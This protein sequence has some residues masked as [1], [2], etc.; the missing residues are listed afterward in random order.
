M[1]DKVIEILKS[2]GY[3]Y[4][5]N[6]YVLLTFCMDKVVS[7]LNS[8]CHTKELPK[9]LEEAAIDRV[10][11]EFLYALKSAG[12]LEEF[13]LEQGV[14]SVKVGD[15][16]VNFSGT[17]PDAAFNNLIGTLRNSGEELIKCFRK[18]QF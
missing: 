10:C 11:G 9:G 14:S 1:E 7:E 12:K 2:I 4:S 8:R 3:E 5:E 16:S 17:S 6:D 13:D 15:T 18:I